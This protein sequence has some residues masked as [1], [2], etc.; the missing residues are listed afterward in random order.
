M[1]SVTN[2]EH[3]KVLLRHTRT[4]M[5]YAGPDQWAEDPAEAL[6]FEMTD[7]ALDAVRDAKLN[8]MEVL[9][10]FEDPHFEIPLSVI[11]DVE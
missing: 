1:C 8:S 9:M 11:G 10:R 5:F 6:D 7:R 2:L 4:K 3:M